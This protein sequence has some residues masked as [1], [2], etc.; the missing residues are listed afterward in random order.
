MTSC[1]A[2]KL[3]RLYGSEPYAQ[4]PYAVA[5]LKQIRKTTQPINVFCLT[6]NHTSWWLVFLVVWERFLR[7]VRLR[8]VEK[9]VREAFKDSDI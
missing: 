2:E 5:I 4:G 6:Q 1:N 9:I 8:R 3:A 7:S